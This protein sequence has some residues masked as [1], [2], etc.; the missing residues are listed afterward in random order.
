[1]KTRFTILFVFLTLWGFSQMEFAPIGAEWYYSQTVG[2]DPP[3]GANYIKHTCFKDSIID[4]KL[5]KVIQKTKFTREGTFELGFE[6]MYQS[7]NTV[8]YWKNGEF[9][10]LYNFSLLKG[11]SM[12]IY[13][14][15]PN[16]CPYNDSQY[17]WININSVFTDT[18]NNKVLKGY[19]ATHKEGSYWGFGF[20]PILEKIGSTDYLL[21]RDEGCIFDRPGIGP[22]RCYSDPELGIFYN[23]KV[24]CDTITTF[25]VYSPKIAK[26]N[27]F[28]FYPNPVIDYLTID[29]S[30][31]G[32]FYFEMYN[33]IGDLLLK[34][35]FSPGNRVDMTNLPGGIYFIIVSN[36]NKYYDDG[37]IY[38]N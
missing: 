35:D 1:M 31:I 34:Q 17:G 11:D 23:G 8:S 29:C 25:P 3:Q 22:L 19:Y 24:P 10:E 38:K 20:R 9:H 5:V 37:I 26:E 32:N 13:S 7:G 36:H 27:H 4:G 30:G 33:S 14:D 2:F 16:D 6:Y 28:K 21:P 15:I 12:L 18:I